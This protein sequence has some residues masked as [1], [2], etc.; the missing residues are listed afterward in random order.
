[1][2]KTARNPEY[3]ISNLIVRILKV[4]C[5]STMQQQR[6]DDLAQIVTIAANDG[7]IQAHSAIVVLCEA[8]EA[9]KYRQRRAE[10]DAQRSE[11][12]IH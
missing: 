12:N 1:M 5:V 6:A 4:P 8:A 9:G 3:Y 7:I 11:N 2:S 10:P